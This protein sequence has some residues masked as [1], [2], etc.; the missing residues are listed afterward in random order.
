MLHSLFLPPEVLRV[1]QM[2]FV[3]CRLLSSRMRLQMA[4]PLLSDGLQRWKK[5]ACTS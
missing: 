4:V 5:Q 3:L 1:S 2:L